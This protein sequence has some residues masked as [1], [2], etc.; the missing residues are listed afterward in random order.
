VREKI[1]KAVFQEPRGKQMRERHKTSKIRSCVILGCGG[2]IGSHL[3]DKLLP[4]GEVFVEGFDLDDRKIGSYL[5]NENFRFHRGALHDPAIWP[6][7]TRSIE[8]SDAVINL[9]A[10]CNPSLY[11]TRP[12]DTIRSNFLDVYEIV[13]LCST[14]SRWLVHLSTSEVYGR[15]IASYLPQNDYGDL[16]LYE[17]DEQATPLIM[18]PIANQR[19]SYAC[20]KQLLERFIYAHHKEGGLPF[21]I[22]RPLN[23]FGPRMDFI[24]G[25]EGEGV[26]RVLACFLGNLL[27]DQPLRVVDGGTSRRTIVSIQDAI[28]ALI[29]M[30]RKPDRAKDQIF[31][32]GNPANE[33]TMLELAHLIRRIYAEVSGNPRYNHHPIEMVSGEV[34]YGEGYEDCDRR[35]PKIERARDR[36]GWQP[37]TSLEET[38]RETVEYYHGL[39]G[40]EANALALAR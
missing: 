38:L 4:A 21:T 9:A 11:N 31:N 40:E 37:T 32:I 35:M 22:V 23:F 20:A 7:L 28:E 25:R 36:L 17:L 29:L 33:V 1:N 16:D 13:E 30:L 3:L 34:F 19:W 24:P 8:E 27:D 18:G 14:H 26:P 5:G 10:I 6:E 2:F 39:Y 15:T 12:L